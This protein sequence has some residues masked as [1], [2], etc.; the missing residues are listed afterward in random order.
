MFRKRIVAGLVAS[1]F[2]M[3]AAAADVLTT[4]SLTSTG[5]ASI[6][7]M[8]LNTMTMG[9]AVLSNPSSLAVGE[10]LFYYATQYF[11]PTIGGTYQFG[12]S[13]APV[14]TVLILYRGSFDPNNPGANAIAGNDDGA[15][16][17]GV[18]ITGCAN[19]PGL[20]PAMSQT[21]DADTD[22]HVVIS[23]YF[24]GTAL[25]LPLEFYVLGSAEVGVGGE[26]PAS[27]AGFVPV[28]TR[29]SLG[30]A[31]AL[32]ALSGDATGDLGA[33]ITA[34]AALPDAERAAALERVAPNTGRSIAAASTGAVR[35]ALDAVSTRLEGVRVQGFQSAARRDLEAGQLMLASTGDASGLL[36]RD[37]T[38]SRG[39]WAKGFGARGEQ[40]ARGGFSGYEASTAGFAIGADTLISGG[41]VVGGAFTYADTGAD[42]QDARLGD[43]TDVQ[44]YQATAYA[45]REFGRWYADGMMAYARHTFGTRRDTGVTGVAAGEFDGAQYALRAGA[46]MPVRIGDSLTLTPFAALELERLETD[47]YAESGAGAL[48]LQVQKTSQN[49]VRSVLGAKLSTTAVWGGYTVQPSA[50]VAWRH[51]FRH[52]GTASTAA[53]TGGGP[54]FTTPGQDLAKDSYN[55]GAALTFTQKR[56]FAATI[57]VDVE[58]ASGYEALAGQIVG[59]WL[60]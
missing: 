22:Y 2:S 19:S 4:F 46:G 38:K 13:S 58:K 11:T 48:S 37:A 42:M 45:T 26:P 44:T 12:Q 41:W 25:S 56:D 32:D 49:R 47:A 24:T 53:F 23:T 59:Q 51:E 33:A 43:K 54:R 55:V 18:T 29:T 30:A 7:S 27:A 17:A 3:H 57:Q 6:Q 40:D 34:L 52:E 5:G 14:D 36:D 10:N 8:S 31:T 1:S 21:L 35:A 60:F 9:N 39:L 20:C 50:H 15:H 28:S 16:P